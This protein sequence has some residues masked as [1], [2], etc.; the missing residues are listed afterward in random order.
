MAW[1]K[2]ATME[3][4]MVSRVVTHISLSIRNVDSWK[5]SIHLERILKSFSFLKR[6]NTQTEWVTALDEKERENLNVVSQSEKC[7]C[8]GR[9]YEAFI[10]HLYYK[11]NKSNE[12][13]RVPRKALISISFYLYEEVYRSKRYYRNK[14]FGYVYSWL[15]D[16]YELQSSDFE[17]YSLNWY[18]QKS[19]Y[20][21]EPVGLGLKN[22]K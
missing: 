19:D 2:R 14:S 12:Y 5:I 16:Q 9:R 10:I 13:L 8:K 7:K 21:K 20:W 22:E 18:H 4:Q 3:F 1:D 17:E 6:G 11:S 15:S